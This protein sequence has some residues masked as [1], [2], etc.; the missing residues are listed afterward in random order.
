[1]R[2]C[3]LRAN[4]GGNTLEMVVSWMR[5]DG[6][7]FSDE[8]IACNGCWG[9]VRAS[10]VERLHRVRLACDGKEAYHGN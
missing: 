9:S 1:M 10:L 8:K 7:S 3:R 6:S 5:C 4:L 2:L